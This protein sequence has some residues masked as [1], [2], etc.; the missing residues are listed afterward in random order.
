MEGI[1]LGLGLS[2]A[3]GSLAF[4]A[5]AL[6]PS[7]FLGAIVVGTSIFG[8][9]GWTWGLLLIL[10]FVSS[11]ALSRYR[12][13][14][15]RPLA[16][17]FAKGRQRD[18]GQTMA[19]G[20]VGALLAAVHT[21]QPSV[22]WTAA[23]LGT[24]AAVNADTWATE[25]GILSR[26]EPRLMSTGQRVPAGTSGAVSPL[27]TAASFAGASIIGLTGMVLFTADRLIAGVGPSL[28]AWALPAGLVG[29]LGGSLTDSLLGATVQRV[30]WCPSCQVE[31]ERA[32]HD[33]G[34]ETR[35]LR[36][37]PWLGND[38]VNGVASAVGA[39]LGAAIYLVIG[40]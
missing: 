20:G 37:W 27:G 26:S 17:M 36:G 2:I 4:W 40:R 38:A 13:P 10:F 35:H 6:T 28:L 30:N 22:L 15:K 14:E 16:G 7:G 24:M 33:C 5:G 21:L 32:V 12:E 1:A 19:N 34:T 25:L 11:S 9:G 23:F 31:T 39:G 3:I 29:G 8:L 18:L